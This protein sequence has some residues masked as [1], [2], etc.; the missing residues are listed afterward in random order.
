M[1]WRPTARSDAFDIALAASLGAAGVALAPH[2][3]R[4]RT[5]WRPSTPTTRGRSGSPSRGLHRAARRPPP[6]APRRA[7]ASSPSPFIPHVVAEIPEFTVSSVALVHRPLHRGRLRGPA[8]ER[9]S[10]GITRRA[11][12]VP[13]RLRARPSRPRTP[14]K[15]P[16]SSSRSSRR[17][18]TPST[19][20]PPGSSATPC[21]SAGSARPSS[22]RPQRRLRAAERSGRAGPCSRSACA[23][24][25]SCTTCSPTTCRSW[26]C[27]PAPLAASSPPG[28]RRC[29]ISSP[30]SRR[31]AATRS[32]SSTT[33]SACCAATTTSHL[34]DGP[35]P[36]VSRLPELVDDMR[37]AGLDVDLRIGD[38]GDRSRRRRPVGLP[39]RAGGADEHPQA[40]GAGRVRRGRDPAQRR[41]PSRSSCATT[42][43]SAGDGSASGT[44]NGLVGMR[45]RVSLPRRRAQSGSPHRRPRLGGAGVAADV[46]V[47]AAATIRVALVDDQALVRAGFRLILEAEPGIEVV[48]EAADGEEA[49]D[50]V[51]RRQP[52]V[53][54]MDIQ[55]PR[56]DGIA[57][58]RRLA[59]R[60]D[61]RRH[62]HHLRARRLH[63]RRRPRR[64][65]RVPAQER[66]AGGARRRRAGGGRGR[67]A[68]VAVG[69]PPRRS[70]GSRPRSRPRPKPPTV[71]PS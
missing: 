52:D 55:M 60:G 6:P 33:S 47:G 49:V 67:R 10:G 1:N 36:G 25:A 15:G 16:S 59:A 62:P 40:R 11:D 39:H 51:R 7:L 12:R 18:R 69:H 53:V 65:Q 63:P 66:A 32:P 4:R 31:R 68:A 8:A 71:S 57:A 21:A 45:E 48:A 35:Q 41:R 50:V 3:R 58:T 5:S 2:R 19:S 24:P 26:A 70:N 14:P 23:S 20:A 46:T 56:L 37:D 27:R 64:R 43:P 22:R 13:R 44:G 54:L 17:R 28:P 42:L 34:A 29:P 30:R 61:D 9:R 38:V